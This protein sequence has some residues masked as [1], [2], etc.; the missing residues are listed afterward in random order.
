MKYKITAL[1]VVVYFNREGDH[2]HNGLM[3]ALTANVPILKYIQALGRVGL[4]P[5]PGQSETPEQWYA[6]AKARA[7]EIGVE[8]PSSPEE[9]RQ[10][11]PLVRPLVLRAR[12]GER[13]QVELRNDIRNRQ[14]G[15][16][17]VGDGYDVRSDDG[18]HVGRNPSSLVGPDERRTYEWC[19]DHEGVFPFHDGGNFSG[20]EDGT[21][22]HGLFGA[23]I[24]EPAGSRW[25]DPVTGR[26]SEDAHGV[27]EL[28]GLYLDVLPPGVPDTC[29]PSNTTL[30][31]HVWPPPVEHPDFD[32]KAHREFVIFFHDEPE[33][34]PPHGAMEPHPC[35]GEDT[36][37]HP[38][39]RMHPGA[40]AGGATGHGGHGD[41]MP[42]M[43]VSYRAEPMINRERILW[44]LLREGHVLQRP[45]LNEEQHHSSW[46]FGDP[47]T[48]ILK[49]YIGDPVRIRLIHAAV[50]ETH[51]FH[52]HLYEWHTVPQDP[53]SPRID[54]ISIGPQTAHTIQPLW[55]A[56]NRHQVAGDVIWHC[57]LY[58]HFH[59]GM[60]GM[61]RTFDTL[62]EGTD[63]PPLQSEDPRYAGRRIGR[64]PDGTRIERLLPLPDPDRPPPPRP[65]PTKPGYPL[66]IPGEVRQKSP[67]PPWPYADR[68]MPGDL[69]YR[70]EPTQL[71]REAFNPTPVP[72]ELF[73]RRPLSVQQTEEYEAN[74]RFGTWNG[75]REVQ[76]DVVVAM[77]P[78][79]YNSQGWHDRHGH[80]FYLAAEGDPATRPG[81]REPLFFRAQHGQILNLTLSNQLPRT[82]PATE[83]DPPFPPCAKLP[84]E[85]E[86]GLHVHMVKF[87]P[88]CGDG[89]SVGWNYL[90]GASFGKKMVYRWWADREFGT[91]FFHD[92]LFANYRQKHGL[93]GA[94]LV[95]PIGAK[96]FHPFEP[97]QE[98][99]SGQQARIQL[100]SDVRGERWFREFCIAIGDHIPMWDRDGRPLNP[101]AHPG[102][103][104]DQGVMGLNYRNTP[105]RERT[106]DPAY[107]F[108]SRQHGDPDTTVFHTYENEPLWIRLVQGSHEE[109]HSFQ[110]HGMRWRRFR[111]NLDSSIRAQ[112][113]LGISEAFTFINNEP[114]G[115]G[116]YL[117]KL[118]AADDLW[119][120]CWG[121]IRALPGDARS[122]AGQDLLPLEADAGAPRAADS[123]APSDL[124]VRRFRVIA[125][126]RRLVYREPDLVDPFGL[127]Y[128][129]VSVQGPGEQAPCPVESNPDEPL[130]L[131]CREGEQVEVTVENRLPPGLRPEPFAP[132]VPVEKDDRRVSQQ[133][134]LHADLV[135]YD[136]T[137]SDG[138][139]VGFNPP[140]TVLPGQE[141]TYVWRATRPP[142]PN[143]NA[144]EPLG[145]VL[146]QDMA[147]FRHHRHHGLIGALII[148]A[149]RA[150]PYAVEAGAA[151]AAPDAPEAWYGA[152]A[153]IVQEGERSEEVVLLMQDGLRLYL[154]GNVNFP[155]P[156]EPGEGPN[157]ADPEDQGQKGFNYRSEPIGPLF[158]PTG[159]EYSLANP[160]PATPVWCVPVGRQV[161]FHLVGALDKPR[162][163]SFTLHGVTWPEWRFLSPTGEPRVSSESAISCGTARTFEFTPL[164]PGDYAYR[165]GVTKWA[166]AQGMWGLLRVVPDVQ[167]NKR[168]RT[169]H[170][171]SDDS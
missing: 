52:L 159:G 138:A 44:R 41:L 127:V 152:R 1:Q 26:L 117:Y 16:H 124:P 140:Q 123:D 51:V 104:G 122:G 58:P 78:I 14:V 143:V 115:A 108:S 153:T 128:R 38:E 107:W 40:P 137:H 160:A 111:A 33:F 132:E 97:E 83:F 88:I 22:A 12:K 71:E 167:D 68:P 129:L 157:A 110:I 100:P 77:R 59:E 121:L 10:P 27:R 5:S 112:Q 75:P 134:S 106:G 82:I 11:H 50:K 62:Q 169:R 144:G 3:F 80:L 76:R 28:D 24:V 170:R 142:S 101:P 7:D 30:D 60:W 136:V 57:H 163:Q 37:G 102:G 145:P 66:Y 96:A 18:A 141:L 90:S 166:L 19:C 74:P 15:L 70:P 79:V 130:V 17:L 53:N 55:G 46:M 155:L 42:I 150:T 54:A 69:D 2:D 126:P 148:E 147:D 85:G 9:A 92:H 135:R 113:T 98:I 73:T 64:Y 99:V 43:P 146:L 13:V 125:E 81:P 168:R 4:P 21:H 120:G 34:V 133:V 93:F 25:R 139:N 162:N 171:G 49:A 35:E 91:I 67:V 103:H 89:A 161:R 31:D 86:C 158:S 56:G 29:A 156:D 119:L 8:L 87:D 61:F 118:S 131:R 95:E 23:L 154:H 65:T 94:L 32:T 39:G 114:F 36:G 47:V 105:I 45:I 116:D 149:P 48:P 109:Q 84:W 72:G 164:H 6:Q 151:T 165:S 63:G 20:G